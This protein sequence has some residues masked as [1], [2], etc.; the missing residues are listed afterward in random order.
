MFVD[1]GAVVFV[2]VAVICCC[3]SF[4]CLLVVVGTG[5]GGVAIALNDHDV[6]VPVGFSHGSVM[7]R[8]SCE[9]DA[10]L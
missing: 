5:V 9:F 3:S 7:N 1:D 6:I 8:N 10:N 2:V 4:S